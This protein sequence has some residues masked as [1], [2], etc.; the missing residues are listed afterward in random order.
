MSDAKLFYVVSGEGEIGTWSKVETVD[1][2]AALK[3]ARCGGDR[4]A[5]AVVDVYETADGWAGTDVE[6]GELRSVPAD[7]I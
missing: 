5:R 7:V 1:I 2:A 4:W 3:S 6:T